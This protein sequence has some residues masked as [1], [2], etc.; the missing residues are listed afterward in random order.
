M[1]LIQLT[2]IRSQPP[3]CTEIIH[4]TKRHKREADSDQDREQDEAEKRQRRRIDIIRRRP[5]WG[6]EHG[7]ESPVIFFESWNDSHNHIMLSVK[8]ARL[9]DNRARR[10]C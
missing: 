8:R 10:W 9:V 4:D 6:K 5:S 1:F 7:A 2:I 3:H